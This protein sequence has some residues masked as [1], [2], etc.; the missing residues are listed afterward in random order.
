MR[1]VLGPIPR[2]R[3]FSPEEEG[4][5]APLREPSSRVFVI[6]VLILSVPLLVSAY[7][8]LLELKE[9]LRAQP[10]GLA[11][12]VSFF[13]L[14]IPVHE[15]IHALVYPGGLGSRHLVMGA[16]IRRG[17]CYVV[18]DAP[19]SRDRILIVLCTPLIL[20]SSA[21]AVVAV[22]VPREWGLLVALCILV[23]AAVCIGD[24]ATFVRLVRQAPKNSVVRNDG[25][26]TY[27]MT[28]A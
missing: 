17:L 3:G 25:W 26:K 22:L 13:V 12:L 16:W 1:L 6:Q 4:G 11:G 19:V 14:M 23:H 8:L 2:S 18:Y 15:T 5:W 21:L 24:L 9:F 28:L 27:W 7:A 10:L 20:V